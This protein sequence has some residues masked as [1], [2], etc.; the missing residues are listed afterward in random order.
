VIRLMLLI[1]TITWMS[2]SLIAAN[3]STGKLPNLTLVSKVTA[4]SNA[5]GPG[6][7]YYV[8]DLKDGSPN[9]WWA[10]A[11]NAPMPQWVKVAF[12]KPTAVDTLVVSGVDMPTLYANWKQIEVTLS[13]GAKVTAALEDKP[14]AQIVRLGSHTVEWLQVNILS[15][16]GQKNYVGCAELMAFNDPE[17][18]VGVRLSA[19]EQ[20]R[21]LKLTREPV[22]RHPTVYLT[23]EDVAAAKQRV[24]D[25]AWAKTMS[26]S[27]LR[28]ADQWVAKP[29]DWFLKVLPAHGACFAYGFTGC[30]IC[31]ASWGTWEGAN[32]TWD[33]PGH[34]RCANG[35]VLPD[36]EHPD[37]GTG[38]VGKDGRIHYFVGSYNAWVVE[39]LE[40]SAAENL[41]LAYSLTGD[42]RYAEKCAVI[43]DGFAN[44]YPSCDKGSWDYPSNPPSGR[45]DRP[46]Y[47]VARVLIWYVDGYDRICN[48]KSLDAPS[49]RAGMTRRQNI[50]ENLLLNGAKYC[51]DQ[52]LHGGL[53]N[54]EADYIRGCLAVGVCL[55]VP[56][57]VHWATTGPFGILPMLENNVDRS[58]HYFEVSQMYSDHTR[59]LYLTFSDP[60][61][62]YRGSLYPSGLN[63][64]DNPKF[65]SFYVF[66]N[67]M[68]QC[69]GHVAR[70]GDDAPDTSRIVPTNQPNSQRDSNLLEYQVARTN[71][72]AKRKEF[73]TLL[74]WM[75][76]DIEKARDGSNDKIWL[77]FHAADVSDAAANEP[78]ELPKVWK[79]RLMESDFVGQKGFGILRAGSGQDAQSVLL[80][81]GPSMNHGHQDD[82]NINYFAAGYEVTYDLGYGLGST[83]TQVGWSRQT[84]SHNLVVVD[85]KSQGGKSGSGGSL[86]LFMDHPTCKVVGASSE[87]SYADR[88]VT[89][90]R[91]TCALVGDG[92]DRYLLDIFRVVGGKQHDF[93][94]HSLTDNAKV[95]GVEMGAEEQGSLAAP[96]ISWGDKQLNDGD[97]A[98]YPNKP[99]W[100][101]PPGNGYGFLIKPQRGKTGSAWQVEWTLSDAVSTR[102]RLLM[103]AQPGT[104][105]ISARAPGIY[106]F[107][108]KA[109]YVVARRKA[110]GDQPLASAFASVVSA[111]S[112][113]RYGEEWRAP[114]IAKVARAERGEVKPI[115]GM[116][117]LLYKGTAAGD[118]MTFERTVEKEGDYT[119]VLHPYNSPRYGS[120][121]VLLDG[122]PLGPVI[123][124]TAETTAPA[125][126][127]ELGSVRLTAGKHQFGLRIEASSSG[128]AA[129]NF[130]M[131]IQSLVFKTGE[132]VEQEKNAKVTCPVTGI[133]RL[134][135]TSSSVSSQPLG[136]RVTLSNGA[137]DYV[138]SSLDPAA[139]LKW[140]K[141]S[142]TGAFARARVD[143]KGQLL[144]L[145]LTR[146]TRFE[147]FGRKFAAPAAEITGTVKD[148]DFEKGVM[149][150]SAKLPTD[151]SLTGRTIV[152]S[153]PAYSRNT[154]YHIR[155]VEQ[156]P[157]GTRVEVEEQTF[158]LGRGE[159]EDDPAEGNTLSSLTPHEYFRAVNRTGDSWFFK[160]KLI[161]AASGASTCV[162][163]GTPGTVPLTLTVESSKGF[164]AGDKLAYCDVQ[165]GDQFTIPT[166]TSWQRP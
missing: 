153:N 19:P 127:V 121:Q 101:P 134:P 53:H 116:D 133:E 32:A 6:G 165:P 150:T 81:F 117:I 141:V 35:R 80:R 155:R 62:N 4:S 130:W 93:M 14:F 47:Q 51:Y 83:H 89:T 52:S 74:R 42:E 87:P 97:M 20:W 28:L 61:Y 70:Y 113:R 24:K 25:H 129:G 37:P 72:P 15:S 92:A 7:K 65:Q 131:G 69:A 111:Y 38:Y 17:K 58:G 84:A 60:L 149:V 34:V 18:K 151:G 36:A 140:E 161:R 29:N 156:T 56:E 64:Y 22:T 147:G 27:I 135:V 124:G 164:H 3:L 55:G 54:G 26:D 11:N 86:H 102:V 110:E 9:T 76:P 154:C 144:Q 145:D 16:H 31:N 132:E 108:P 90:Y 73:E 49:V 5:G 30:P 79:R 41:A 109:R 128:D 126:E 43:L 95:E 163:S 157:Q 99:Y 98:G 77:L 50:E 71:D 139:T 118:T 138:F 21:D 158:V 94:F 115:D 166:E 66:P 44:I 39:Q 82:L 46:W 162:L 75:N 1:F 137:T 119:I 104:E 68:I 63:L 120:A 103:A 159:V 160:G 91:R 105:V 45:F 100:N 136:L 143:A 148:A 122:K 57:Y 125:R 2:E 106:P 8:D 114:D 10:C 33:N 112:P 85:E 13:D 67:L 123:K 23:P 59:S 12:D 40:F 107:Y 48:S 78:V 146:S 142:F 152:F 88:G 96:D